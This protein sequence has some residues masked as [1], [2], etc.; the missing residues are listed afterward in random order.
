MLVGK[1]A[2]CLRRINVSFRQSY[3][4]DLRHCGDSIKALPIAVFGSALIH[5]GW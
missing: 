5:L 3:R 2:M 4:G 1:A